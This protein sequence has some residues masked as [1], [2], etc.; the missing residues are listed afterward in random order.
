MQVGEEDQ[1]GAQ[2]RQ[3]VAQ[4]GALRVLGGVEGLGV[5]KAGLG[6]DQVAG[7]MQRAHDDAGHR[8]DQDADGDFLGDQDHQRHGGVRRDRGIGAVHLRRQGEG[9]RQ[10]QHQAHAGRNAG[11]ADCGSSMTIAPTRENTS[12]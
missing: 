5:G 6:G 3:E 9:N 2:Q 4:H 11:F 7:D 12:R 1:R 8:A 10:R